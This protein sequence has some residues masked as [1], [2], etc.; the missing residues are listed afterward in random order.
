MLFDVSLVLLSFA[1]KSLLSAQNQQEFIAIFQKFLNEFSDY[2]KFLEAM[3]N[4]YINK[5][6]LAKVRD[7]LL[8]SDYEQFKLSSSKL[9]QE[10]DHFCLPGQPLCFR[11]DDQSPTT[12]LP[13][14]LAAANILSRLFVDHYNVSKKYNPHDQVFSKSPH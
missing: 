4:F 6:L 3:R 5:P 13:F 14:S 7:Q 2:N 1:E 12:K 10:T 11:N 9:K 8:R